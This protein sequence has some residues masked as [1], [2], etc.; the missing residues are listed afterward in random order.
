MKRK[1]AMAIV[2]VAAMTVT[3]LAGCGSSA[4]DTAATPAADSAATDTRADS[5]AR[6][7][8]GFG[9]SYNAESGRLGKR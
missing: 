4:S 7:I 3:M 8:S 1:K 5:T 2:M 9:G 6:H